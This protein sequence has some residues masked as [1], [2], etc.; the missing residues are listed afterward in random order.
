MLHLNIINSNTI[1][2][3]NLKF[4]LQLVH[5]LIRIFILVKTI[6]SALR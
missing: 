2:S 1:F 4:K 6:F 3:I 5:F